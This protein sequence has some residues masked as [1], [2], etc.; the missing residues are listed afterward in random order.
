MLFLKNTLLLL[1][2]IILSTSVIAQPDNEEKISKKISALVKEAEDALFRFDAEEAEGL[3]LNILKKKSDYVVAQRGLAT[4]YQMQNRFKEAAVLL[5]KIVETKPYFSRVIYA[6]V[7][8]AHYRYGNYD[9]AAKYFN[10]FD[11]IIKLPVIDFGINGNYEMEIEYE[12]RSKLPENL[13]A[14]NIAK[15]SIFNKNVSSVDNLDLPIN[16]PSNEYFPFL[17]NDQELLYFTRQISPFTD[18]NLFFSQ[19]GDT[20]WNFATYIDSVFNT[21]VNEGMATFTRDGRQMFFTACQRRDVGGTCDIRKA[22]IKRDQIINTEILDGLVNTQK[23]ESQACISCDGSALFFSSNR[24]GG[25]GSTDLYVSYIQEDDTWSEAQ[26]LGPNVNTNKDEESPFITNDGK[27]LFFSSTGHLGMGEQDLFMSRLQDDGI[28]GEAINLGPPINTA[29]RELG[30]FLSADGLT[31]LFSSNRPGGQGQMDIYEFSLST[32]LS[33][34]PISYVEGYVKDSITLAPIQTVLYPKNHKPVPTDKEG[35]FFLCLKAEANF[36]FKIN[37]DK[38]LP[39]K[40]KDLIPVWDNKTLYPIEILLQP[41]S[42]SKP[43]LE[44]KSDS[45]PKIDSFSEIAYF[46]FDKSSLT[47]KAQN[48]LTQFSK[49]LKNKKIQSIEIIGYSDYIGTDQYNIILSKERAKKVADFLIE[50][51]VII[52]ED[53]KLKTSIQGKGEI[54]NQNPRADNRRVEIRFNVY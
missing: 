1:L 45:I 3:Y 24:P 51:G 36:D 12:Y 53:S 2:F 27:T 54:N 18:E 44:P 32:E 4:A 21:P 34:E 35:R 28:W 23:W 6:D 39:F 49:N 14:C 10:Q 52:P 19:K 15:D 29:Y 25:I 26:N 33:S 47:K 48:K 11:S 31:G 37:E 20:S 13:R 9:A 43:E 17:T 50:Q 46:D 38:Y 8:I 40:R 41:L 16:T 7:A 30:F 22:N 42:I 5:E